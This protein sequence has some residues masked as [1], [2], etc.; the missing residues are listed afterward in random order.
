MSIPIHQIKENSERAPLLHVE[1]P[2]TN[3][4]LTVSMI[5]ITAL[6]LAI[7]LPGSSL[8]WFT[9]GTVAAGLSIRHFVKD[10]DRKIL[11]LNPSFLSTT[12]IAM[13]TVVGLGYM[14]VLA[15]KGLVFGI[16][17]LI[18]LYGLY[19]LMS[20]RGVSVSTSVFRQ[21]PVQPKAVFNAITSRLEEK[22]F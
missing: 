21:L 1:A 22:S 10:K 4:V 20:D 6:R 2:S 5:G 13:G 8:G 12:L 18:A 11:F 17:V 14:T 7:L 15:V 16:F 19:T 9:I 3:T